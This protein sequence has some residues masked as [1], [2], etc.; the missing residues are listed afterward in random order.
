MNFDKWPEQGS[1]I[2]RRVEV[3][4]SYDTNK[5]L[6]GKVVRDDAEGV[7]V[8]ALDD[9]RYVLGSE[10]QYSPVTDDASR[11]LPPSCRCDKTESKCSLPTISGPT[12]LTA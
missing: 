9:G 1:F 3:C 10:C 12:L 2:G 11:Q 8:I 6:F 4:F 5:T 7:T